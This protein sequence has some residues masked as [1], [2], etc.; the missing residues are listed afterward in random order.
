[1][2]KLVCC[3]ALAGSLTFQ[4]AAESSTT[5]ILDG[6]TTN[7]AGPFILG[8]TGPFNFLL[9]TNGGALTNTVGTIGNSNAAFGNLAIVTGLGS[10]WA[11]APTLTIGVRGASNQVS[12]LDGARLVSSVAIGLGTYDTSLGNRLLI[13]GT[14]SALSADRLFLGTYSSHNEFIAEQ[15][16]RVELN[17]LIV[18][19]EQSSI[20]RNSAVFRNTGTVVSNASVFIGGS[21]S[22]LVMVS[23]GARFLG[24]SINLGTSFRASANHLDVSGLGTSVTLRN[25]MT[26]GQF[27]SN[28]LATLTDS[29]TLLAERIDVGTHS[30]SNQL[31]LRSASRVV[32]TRIPN[33]NA[34][35]VLGS[36]AGANDNLLLI[37]NPGT[38]WSNS[39]YIFM[40]ASGS[41]NAMILSNGAAFSDSHAGIG[42]IIA[43]DSTASAGNLLHV[44]GTG[45]MLISR[46]GLTV[47]RSGS[48]NLL[49]QSEG[50]R[51]VTASVDI[52]QGC[53]ARENL[54]F[55]TGAGTVWSN[56]QLQVG[57][58]STN[59][60]LVVSNGAQVFAG[61]VRS[62]VQG[63]ASNTM[64]VTG[65][66]SL[67]RAAGDLIVGN[68]GT[69]NSLLIADGGRVEGRNDRIGWSGGNHAASL[70]STGT[71]WS[72][73]SLTI[74]DSTPDNHL[75]VADGARIDS[76]G[77]M[78]GAGSKSSGNGAMLSDSGTVWNIATN[79]MLGGLGH[80]NRLSISEGAGLAARD[81]FLGAGSLLN[82]TAL[83]NSDWNRL[84]L[85]N[86]ALNVASNLT[87]GASGRWNRM[88]VR[89]GSQV[90]G[91]VGVIGLSYGSGSNS[92]VVAGH[93]SAW[94]NTGYLLVGSNGMRNE[95][96][97]SQGGY[98]ND[99]TGY[100]G[101]NGQPLG[102]GSDCATRQGGNKVLVTDPGTLWETA[103]SLY[104]GFG[105]IGNT[106][107]VSNGGTVSAGSLTIGETSGIEPGSLCAP[108]AEFNQVI[109][110]GGRLTFPG[111]FSGGPI[112]VRHGTLAVRRGLVFGGR[113]TVTNGSA[114]RIKLEGGTLRTSDARIRNTE[115]LDVGDGWH[116]ARLH[117]DGGDSLI[118]F[119]N[120]RPHST[121]QARGYLG[122]TLITN[123]GMFSPGLNGV[124][125]L[126]MGGGVAGITQRPGSWFVVD[127]GGSDFDDI[128]FVGLKGALHLDGFLQIRLRN[129]FVPSSNQTFNVAYADSRTGTFSNVASGARLNTA[130]N[131]G[132][133][134]VDYA[135]NRI[136]LTG[137]QST[138]LDG[139]RIEDAWATNHFGH[140][141][142]TP[143]ERLA[144]ADGDGANN[145]EEFRAGTDPNAPAS[146]LRL[147]IA[148]A[149]DRATVSFPCVDGKEY[150]IWSSNNL[151]TWTEVTDPTFAYPWPGRC[152]WTDDG[153]DT[154][155]LGAASRFYRVTVD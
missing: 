39:G 51:L 90:S 130:N 105:G 144:D 50:A 66:G 38:I 9:I 149:G 79:L 12:I 64:T 2:K 46:H 111:G 27:G 150:R 88:E 138:D 18:N 26:V 48:Q 155:G 82:P 124:G 76:G 28:N 3:M 139:D 106:L 44:T 74:G 32:N 58:C 57:F 30:S 141:P 43:G 119:I 55:I 154:G 132:S 112:N 126:S 31:L 94:R 60:H 53:V 116:S 23:D 118:E 103:G 102:F 78:L 4:A 49:L 127:V 36:S 85:S 8:D 92:V 110:D 153:K 47:G 135:T 20:G 122:G 152:E 72:N 16:A 42:G 80:S 140:S 125:S 81:V 11:S 107:V 84:F 40:G 14:G 115:P 52:G 54:A 133:F 67:L 6:V 151:K 99:N 19:S 129:G 71:S 101:F 22:N 86:A 146:A 98:V 37:E 117:I 24:D 142:L 96:T 145:Y 89:D 134:V 136:F 137:Y 25:G 77:A 100:I 121:L 143:A 1:M 114:S 59:N 113:L 123:G 97:I 33:A 7:A 104:V 109:V 63:G 73:T 56:G 69:A 95:L 17:Q 91:R 21:P 68:S 148:Y 65:P 13:S 5:N 29:A 34:S 120:V 75:T 93:A 147:S 10:V 41:R 61:L 128:D 15:G 83:F 131:L 62:S 45:T 87:V 70:F 35:L 108:T